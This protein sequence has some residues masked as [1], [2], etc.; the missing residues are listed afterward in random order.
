MTMLSILVAVCLASTSQAAPR[1]PPAVAQEL[2]VA[3]NG[4]SLQ[5]NNLRNL[6][7]KLL[8]LST[9]QNRLA[10]SLA[11]SNGSRMRTRQI[12][13]QLLER[14]TRS[15]KP[16]SAQTLRALRDAAEADAQADTAMNAVLRTL[17]Q[18]ITSTRALSVE[19]EDYK[20]KI[21]EIR[22]RIFSIR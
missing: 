9:L 2:R 22:S 17:A 15:G 8:N 7:S 4:L 11:N 14:D 5:E 16:L 21:Q 13:D 12:A 18:S 6:S 1:V 19:S 3:A 20:D 10:T